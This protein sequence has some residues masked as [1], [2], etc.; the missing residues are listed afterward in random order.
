MGWRT[1]GGGGSGRV[2]RRGVVV[3][4]AMLPAGGGRRRFGR[5][6]VG[7]SGGWRKK[8]TEMREKEACWWAVAH[9]APQCAAPR[10]G[11]HVHT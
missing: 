5:Q 4:V 3:A 11:D 9:V 2:G 7:R 1:G 8:M 10:R 6:W